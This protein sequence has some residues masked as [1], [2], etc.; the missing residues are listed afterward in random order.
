MDLKI[1][2]IPNIHSIEKINNPNSLDISIKSPE[3]EAVKINS[4]DI[5]NSLNINKGSAIPQFSLVLSK[6]PNEIKEN[7][8][9]MSVY[10]KENLKDFFETDSLNKIQK[11]IGSEETGELDNETINGISNFMN[12]DNFLK[13]Q[14]DNIMKY[15]EFEATINIFKIQMKMLDQALQTLK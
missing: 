13:D 5:Y 14:I 3:K 11:T 2:S 8:K 15:R 1:N 4:S 10:I 12:A 6:D 7:L 9:E